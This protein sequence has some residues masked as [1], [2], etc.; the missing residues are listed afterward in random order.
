ML[1]HKKDEKILT[2][3]TT[4]SVTKFTM[5]GHN[6]FNIYR[7]FST[8]KSITIIQILTIYKIHYMEM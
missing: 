6:P 7:T 1:R 4:S 5:L 2:K 3:F 8:L